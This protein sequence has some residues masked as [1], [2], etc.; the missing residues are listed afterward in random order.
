MRAFEDRSVAVDALR[1]AAALAVMIHHL[2]R[3][4]AAPFATTWWATLPAQFGYLGVILFLVLSGYCIHFRNAQALAAGRLTDV[5]WRDFFRR[6][7]LRLYPAYFAALLIT[8]AFNVA[9]L[10]TAPAQQI[11][12]DL[13]SH[14]TFSHNLMRDYCLGWFNVALWTVGLEFQL[15]LLYPVYLGARRRWPAGRVLMIAGSISGI[16]LFGTTATSIAIFRATGTPVDQQSI[17]PIGRWGFWPIGY[18]FAWVLG[19]VAA[20]YAV[21]AA[22]ALSRLFHWKTIV[23]AACLAFI[24]SDRTLWMVIKQSPIVGWTGG[25]YIK[26]LSRC[27]GALTDPI[28]AV[29]C[30][31]IIINFTR[32][33]ISQRWF[34]P[35][36]SIGVASYSLCLTHV[37]MIDVVSRYWSGPPTV[38]KSLLIS[39]VCIG[40]G[41]LCYRLVEGPC[42]RALRRPRAAVPA[43]ALRRAA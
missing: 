2:P 3:P 40:L 16:W 10:R 42:L 15:Y 11:A 9:A 6:R 35:L 26:D 5:N 14:L 7:V 28:F 8:A 27:I 1:G 37:P 32:W 17:G 25:R 12:G 20:E 43:T 4:A 18:W 13:V 23:V 19:A 38:G 21:G 41:F 30:A 34:A 39:A 24:I 36:S 29:A 33:Q 31:A 22:P